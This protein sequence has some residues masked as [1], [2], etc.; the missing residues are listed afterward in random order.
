MKQH[1]QADSALYIFPVACQ[2]IISPGCHQI[3][4][5][6]CLFCNFIFS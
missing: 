1:Q 5:V 2:L 4:R 3:V 6:D